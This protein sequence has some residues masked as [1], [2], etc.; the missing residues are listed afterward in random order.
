MMRMI[1][2]LTIALL[3]LTPCLH[4]SAAVSAQQLSDASPPPNVILIMTDD[5]GYGDLG[6]Y[7]ATDVNTPN[8]DRLAHE[9]VLLTDFYAAPQCTPTRAS[10]ITGRY[11]Q[12]VALERAMGSV[13]PSLEQGLRATGHSL[14]QLLKDN[15]Y[16]TALIGKWHLGYKSEYGPNAHGFDYF[17]GNLSGYV[18]YYTHIRSGDGERDLFEN[19][20]PVYREGYLTDLT[21]EAALRFVRQKAEQPFFLSLAY[22]APHWPFQRPDQ[23]SEA[24]DRG[25]FQSPAHD[26][27]ATRE[28]YVAMLER[29]DEGVGELLSVLDELDLTR[30]TLVI[31]TNDNGGEW[32]SRSG[33]LFNRKDTL[34]EGGIRVPTIFRWTGSLPEGLS[35]NQVGITMD[36]TATILAVTGTPVPAEAPR[37][38]GI[39]LVPILQGR[40]PVAE[41]TL[42]WRIDTSNRQQRAVRSGRWKL[43]VDGGSLLLFDLQTDLAE[44]NDLAMHRTDLVRKLRAL[45]GE[46]EE[47][48]DSEAM[49]NQAS[50]SVSPPPR[51]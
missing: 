1:R 13:G 47:D 29:V 44:R 35:S 3:S 18:D 34:W 21:T 42:F 9:G 48:V 11:Q 50:H 14:P 22:N 2:S 7:G 30:R 45:I 41:R 8:I 43:L 28:D 19:T 37:P 51:L 31:F 38:E 17:F 46:W 10:L 16:S 23:Y 27:A 40:A 15:G 36:L 32:L 49:A 5:M 20:T 6:S 39:N 26:P 12:R 25:R 4:A 33:P 24:P